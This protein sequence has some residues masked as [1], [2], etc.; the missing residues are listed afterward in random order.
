MSADIDAG[1][2]A[3]HVPAG[4]WIPEI[5]LK[6]KIAGSGLR[7][8]ATTEAAEPKWR[9][10]SLRLAGPRLWSRPA[11][12]AARAESPPKLQKSTGSRPEAGTPAGPGVVRP[13]E[14][15]PP[16]TRTLP[17][18]R[19]EARGRGEKEVSP[20]PGSERLGRGRLPH[21]RLSSPEERCQRR[22]SAK[23]RRR[24]AS[25]PGRRNR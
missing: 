23:P 19:A 3:T 24:G 13:A 14:T 11:D 12:A 25:S 8:P 15:E 21:E 16:E 5:P 17:S 22:S 10:G 1:D 7:A 18:R 6:W 20:A 4:S 9:L 2:I